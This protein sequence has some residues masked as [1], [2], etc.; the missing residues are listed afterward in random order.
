M[1]KIVISE[2]M[3]NAAVETLR[4]RH[5]VH[6]DETLFERTEELKKA[7]CDAVALIV[8]NRTQVTA[9]MIDAAPKLRAVGRLGVGLD[10]IDLE[11]CK[12]RGIAVLPAVGA[13]AASVAEYVLCTAMML[14]RSPAYFSTRRLQ[15]GEWPRAEL[16]R[17]REISGKILGIVGFGSIGQTA[18]QLA[19]A[20]GFHT[21]AYDEFI[22][23]DHSAWSTTEQASTLDVLL[24]SADVVS[25]HCPLTRE[26]RN[27]FSA[28]QLAAMKPG[29]I[30]INTARGGIV[31]ETALAEALRSGHLGGAAIDVFTSEPIDTATAALFAG[32]PNVILTPHVAGVTVES[33]KRISAITAENVISSLEETSR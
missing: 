2:F 19:R 13:N 24:R 18:A 33:N 6:L 4:A 28:P 32:L 12:A 15:R 27:L 7:T 17:G 23:A 5:E 16:S 8:R 11:A 26:T 9:E 3:D 10:N 30:L 14:L 1:P 31:D 22:P 21:L 20:A 25:L 29:A